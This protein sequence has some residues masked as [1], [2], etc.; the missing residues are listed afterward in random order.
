M[1]IAFLVMDFREVDRSY[2]EVTPRFNGGNA[3]L[4]EGFA[5][6]PEVQL[7]VVSC[8]QQPVQSP[9]KLAENIWYHALQVPKI[10]WLRTGYQG[11][12][13]AV[14][15]KLRE[16]QP[17]IVQGV[18]TERDM[19][20]SAV[21]SG[22]PNVV[23][24][25]GNMAEIARLTQARIGSF[26]WLSAR[27]E[28]FI[29]PRTTGVFCNSAYTEELVRP[30]ARRVWRMPHPLRQ[31]FLDPAPDPA[32]R[33]CVLLNVGVI[34]PRKRQLELLDVAEALH[35]QG[36]KFEF[37][38]VGFTHPAAG[39][40]AEAFFKRIKPM[41]SAGY[42]RYLGA[43]PD[44]ELLQVYDSASAMVHFPTEESFGMVVLES[45]GRDLKFFGARLGGI[46]DI[47]NDL[48]GA[49]LFAGNDWAGLTAAIARWIAQGHPRPIGSAA[50]IRER[51]HPLAL[52]RQHIKIYQEIISAPP[53]R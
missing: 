2:A 13:R 33:P 25:M 20:I 10:G 51:Y 34:S 4:F 23:T 43:P 47:A 9:E 32:P 38:F 37:R 3:S 24:I 52:A 36:L 5:R 29:L 18:G 46:V 11:C 40:Y 30:R 1:K 17:D 45:L 15:R 19:A 27:L 42:A 53:I 12:I 16:I 14:R 44:N 28:N 39:A 22:F 31:S 35:R 41:E 48:P 21:F 50:L 8:L 6:L 26:Y 49:E 7:H